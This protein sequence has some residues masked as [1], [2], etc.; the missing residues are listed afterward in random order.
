MPLFLRSS[1]HQDQYVSDLRAAYLG[2]RLF[3]PDQAFAQDPAVWDKMLRDPVIRHA[4]QSRCY[5]IAG[6]KWQMQPASDGEPDKAAA[7]ILEELLTKIRGF[8]AARY[9]LAQGVFHG[10]SY[11]YTNGVA[12]LP[13]RR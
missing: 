13:R 2:L 9:R 4:V 5:S 10:R 11:A 7:G 6:C 12:P 1:A 8:T 3:D